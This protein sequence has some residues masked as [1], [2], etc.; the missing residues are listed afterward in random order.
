M[1]KASNAGEHEKSI[2]KGFFKNMFDLAYSI[3][4]DHKYI[5]TKLTVYIII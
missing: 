5:F 1:A 4:C 3:V 2:C